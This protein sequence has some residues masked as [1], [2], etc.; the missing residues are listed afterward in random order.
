MDLSRTDVLP[1]RL[2]PGTAVW[3]ARTVQLGLPTTALSIYSKRV[4]VRCWDIAVDAELFIHGVAPPLRALS[5]APFCFL[6]FIFTWAILQVE[7]WI[8]GNTFGNE[9]E[10]PLG[11]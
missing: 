6:L 8:A 2:T 4:L 10:K 5:A 1:C 7:R 11:R 9:V 3:D